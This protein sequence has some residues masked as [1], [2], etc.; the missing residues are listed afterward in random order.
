[1][2]LRICA[3]H[4]C[5]ISDREHVLG[6][7][8]QLTCILLISGFLQF[9]WSAWGLWHCLSFPYSILYH[10]MNRR[11]RRSFLVTRMSTPRFSGQILVKP[12]QEMGRA[13]DQN[14]PKGR[15]QNACVPWQNHILARWAHWNVLCFCIAKHGRLS[16][17]V[18]AGCM[19]SYVRQCKEMEVAWWRNAGPKERHFVCSRM[20]IC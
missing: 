7:M 18:C 17:C 13:T 3:S 6:R 16:R 15:R 8:G 20:T 2:H 11:T 10:L 12:G 9:S 19:Y 4:V 5:R 14:G 1:M